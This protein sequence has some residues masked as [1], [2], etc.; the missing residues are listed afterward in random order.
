MDI[1]ATRYISGNETRFP[2][3]TDYDNFYCIT[4]TEQLAIKG[5]KNIDLFVEDKVLRLLDALYVSSLIKNLINTIRLWY[6]V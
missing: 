3:L 1:G 5:K 6:N 2:N 4:N